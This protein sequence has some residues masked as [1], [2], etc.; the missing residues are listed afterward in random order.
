MMNKLEQYVPLIEREIEASV[1]ALTGENGERYTDHNP[2]LTEFAYTVSGSLPAPETLEAPAQESSALLT[3]KEVLWT[4]ARLLQALLG[5]V[6]LPYLAYQGVD[7]L[8]NGSRP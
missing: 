7:L 8:V 5:L 1:P 3:F 2:M 4:F 6:E